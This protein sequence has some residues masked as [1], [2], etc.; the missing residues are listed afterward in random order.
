[1]NGREAPADHRLEYMVLAPANPIEQPG[2]WKL[3]DANWREWSAEQMQDLPQADAALVRCCDGPLFAVA[4]PV[5]SD[6]TNLVCVIAGP[7]SIR[8]TPGLSVEQA[9]RHA[10]VIEPTY[11]YAVTRRG[12]LVQ[13]FQVGSGL[14]AVHEVDPIGLERASHLPGLHAGSRYRLRLT[15]SPQH[16]SQ[17]GPAID[18]DP[19]EFDAPA[20]LLI[21]W[22]ALDGIE[23]TLEQYASGDPIPA[24]T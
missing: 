17:Y 24:A 11:E 4:S 19:I 13:G 9:T 16:S 6:L 7:T 14:A 20:E 3:V 23:I 12:E 21:A 10:V 5:W 18:A 1:M 22:R 8:F 2:L 15:S